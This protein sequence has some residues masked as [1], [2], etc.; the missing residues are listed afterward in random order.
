MKE[1]S[2]ISLENSVYHSLLRIFMVVLAFVLVFDSGI[3]NKQTSRISSSTQNFLASVVGVGASVEPTEINQLTARITELEKEVEAKE[4]IIEVSLN[5][6]GSTVAESTIFLSVALAVVLLLII[7]N[8][9]L[10]F[11]RYRQF[12]IKKSEVAV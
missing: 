1:K 9:I 11:L 5:K 10:D 12:K 8:Y 3:I 6:D 4:R 7:L 2:F